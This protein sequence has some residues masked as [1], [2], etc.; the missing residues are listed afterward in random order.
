MYIFSNSFLFTFTYA[1]TFIHSFMPA[2][3][4]SL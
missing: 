2:V 4:F 1:V 3:L